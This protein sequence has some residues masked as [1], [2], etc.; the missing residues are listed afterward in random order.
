MPAADLIDA[1]A[2]I[3]WAIDQQ[4]K[5]AKRIGSKAGRAMQT[6]FVASSWPVRT[7]T[8]S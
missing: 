6:P 5:L 8:V 4:P 3:D 7:R 1:Q 2:A